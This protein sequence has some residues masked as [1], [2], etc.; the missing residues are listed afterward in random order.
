MLSVKCSVSTKFRCL[1]SHYRRPSDAAPPADDVH[2]DPLNS[3]VDHLAAPNVPATA[4]STVATTKTANA[5]GALGKELTWTPRTLRGPPPEWLVRL[6]QSAYAGPQYH[7]ETALHFAV[8]HRDLEL[9]RKLV[10]AGAD[11]DA[12]ADGLF[13]YERVNTYFGG[14]PVGLAAHLGKLEIPKHNPRTPALAPIPT[15]APAPLQAIPSSKTPTPT[16]TPQPPTP[17]PT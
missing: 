2:L 11:V 5:N 4:E 7:G 9:V 8:V 16:P 17:A 6:V 15:L 3:A 13:F 1:F 12:H 14:R 10:D